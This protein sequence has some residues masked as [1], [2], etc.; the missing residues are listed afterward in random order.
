MV[1]RRAAARIDV[2][3]VHR[4]YQTAA[5]AAAVIEGTELALQ[6]QGL[7]DSY[8]GRQYLPAAAPAARPACRTGGDL[9][10]KR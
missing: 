6:A 2:L 8:L 4:Q 10:K 5:Y 1:L 7:F 3:G 9:Q